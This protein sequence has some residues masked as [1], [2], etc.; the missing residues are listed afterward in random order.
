M[1]ESRAVNYARFRAELGTLALKYEAKG[2][3]FDE[4]KKLAV[5]GLEGLKKD[6]EMLSQ[7]DED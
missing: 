2:V 5:S 1:S 4:M 7:L 6:A 3:S